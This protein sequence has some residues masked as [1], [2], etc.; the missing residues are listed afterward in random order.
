MAGCL[1]MLL[2]GNPAAAE[3]ICWEDIAA[4]VDWC[5]YGDGDVQ[6]EIHWATVDLTVPELY[7][8]VTREE[9][10]PL[11]TSEEALNLGSTVTINGDWESSL[12]DGPHG[13]SV[14]NGWRF[15]DSHDWDSSINPPG[16]WSFLACDAKKQCR[17]NPP[18]LKEEW[19]WDEVNIIGGNGARLVIDGVLQEPT[20]DACTRPRSGVCLNEAGT[21][22]TFFTAEGDNVCDSATGWTPQAFAAFVYEHGCHDGLMLDGGGSADLV[23][24]GIHV[25]DRPP[26]EPDER[27]THNHLSIVHGE[28]VDP[29]CSELMNG[30]R[31]EGE[32]LITCQGGASDP[33]DCSFFG[34]TCEEGSGT[35]YCVYSDCTNGANGDVC[36]DDSVMTQCHLG[37]PL[38]FNCGNVFGAS[39]EDTPGG[40]RCVMVGCDYGGDASWCDGDTLKTCAPNDEGA[41]VMSILSQVDCAETAQVCVNAACVAPAVEAEPDAG[42]GDE[43]DGGDGPDTE[44]PG[45]DSEAPEPDSEAPE[46]DTEA[47]AEPDT[48]GPE[49]DSEGPEPDSEGPEPDSEGPEPDSEG[50]ESDVEGPTD[51]DAS[52][53]DQGG[54]TPAANTDGVVTVPY[55]PNMPTTS[56]SPKKSGGCA[57]DGGAPPAPLP[58]WVL[59]GLFILRRRARS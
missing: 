10:A 16:D 33:A 32:I 15:T 29:A 1:A 20:Y 43:T 51:P 55:T 12:Y 59:L 18:N 21:V 23:L 38:E 50:P 14:G 6:S 36:Q 48:E 58:L 9:D 26:S 44:G 5:V 25:T 19:M 27:S 54:T 4:G 37:Q 39:C 24:E 13:L 35:A 7:I 3:E 42:E 46:P 45:P 52:D 41:V 17:F 49:P 8:R 47:P 2:W 34:A 31:C 40:A 57:G 28:T 56:P 11:T 30:R 53:D 22:M